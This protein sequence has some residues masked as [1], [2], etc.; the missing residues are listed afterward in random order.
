MRSHV[1]SIAH[2]SR[3][4]ALLV[5][6][7]V[8]SELT[9][10]GG[11]GGG[12]AGLSTGGTGSFSSGTITGLGSIIV[13]GVRYDNDGVG[14]VS[15]EDGSSV[16]T[17]LSLGMVVTVEGSDVTPSTAP[18]GIPT[19]RASRIRMGSEW[20]GPIA[21]LDTVTSTFA[22]LGNGVD[23]LSTTL[24]GGDASQLS[25]LSGLAY[26]EVHG[27]V[28][29]ST[30]RLQATL[31]VATNVAPTF[32]KMS[33]IVASLTTNTSFMLGNALISYN[34]NTPATGTWT[35]GTRIKV[36]LQTTQQAGAWPALRIFPI[37]S[38]T[39]DV[40]SS[41]RPAIG[42]HG[43]IARYASG[44][45]TVFYVEE[46]RV[47]ASGVVNFTPPA[48]GTT[49]DVTGTLVN[50][51]LVASTVTAQTRTQIEA[52]QFEFV[53]KITNKT[54]TTFDLKGIT[55]SYDNGTVFSGITLSNY[56]NQTVELKATHLNGVWKAVQVSIDN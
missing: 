16:S 9:G 2:C 56:A 25:D 41:R 28:D 37:S 51:V 10:C 31:V 13:N 40:D 7:G 27:Y 18:D 17:P 19:S 32:F 44:S 6:A 8:A 48:V 24:F 4:N 50:G 5:L 42:V 23:V 55:F 11:G 38:P 21:G 30:G 52:K 39:S 43:K 3:R 35:T 15:N 45:T 12:V 54:S 53:G 33:G 1:E 14:V 49:V 20:I 47:D 46:M 34:A 26:A 22:L 29:A 36:R